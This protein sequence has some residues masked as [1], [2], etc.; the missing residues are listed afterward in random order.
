M[1]PWLGLD[2]ISGVGPVSAGVPAKAAFAFRVFGVC[3]FDRIGSRGEFS[4]IVGTHDEERIADELARAG[5]KYRRI[6][7]KRVVT[8]LIGLGELSASRIL[9]FCKAEGAMRPQGY[10]QFRHDC[11]CVPE[12]ISIRKGGLQSGW[13]EIGVP[14]NLPMRSASSTLSG[15]VVT[16]AEIV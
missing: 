7:N 8:G 1:R 9:Q 2:A 6:N 13:M 3:G 5:E 15:H 14:R 10:A 4:F 12:R 11:S 16:N